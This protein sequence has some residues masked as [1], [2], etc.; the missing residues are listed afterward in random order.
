MDEL[1]KLIDVLEQKGKSSAS[2]LL[3]YSD[4]ESLE[5]RLYQLVREGQPT[6]EKILI[7]ALYGS[8]ATT[9]AY[10][11]LKS[12]VK[13]KLYN[14]LFFLDTENTRIADELAI[15]EVKCRKILYLADLLRKLQEAAFA[16]QQ[17]RKAIALAKESQ[18]IKYEID[19]LEQLRM[20][21]SERNFS[22][23]E[24]NECVERLKI[25]YS[26]LEI[27]KKADNIYYE[28]RFS[29]KLGVHASNE[30]IVKLP[31]MIDR[32]LMFWKA[33]DS[34][35]VFRR[36]HQLKMFYYE[37][38]GDFE[39]FI[40]YLKEIF[41]VYYSGKIHPL[42]FSINF[43]K[44]LLVFAYLRAKQYKEGIK[45]AEE[46][47]T[48]I[49]EGSH[50]WFANMENYFLLAA[51]SKN[52]SKAEELLTEALSNKYL[53]EITSFA[54][55][56]WQLFYQ[57]LN[58]I[59]G[60]TSPTYSGSKLKHVPQDKKG[61]NVWRL[62][63]DFILTL[64]EEDPELIEREI[65]RVRKFSTKYLTAKEDARTKTFLKLL[66]VVGREFSDSKV[67]KRKGAYLFSKLQELPAP[68]IAY[69]ETEI[70]PYEHLWGLILEKMESNK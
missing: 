37:L 13:K 11:M 4:V 17:L 56:R 51:H 69:A 40:L 27:E 22:S 31:E 42:Y 14:Q 34:S 52:Y 1:K 28:I 49:K 25:L 36:Y 19:A 66:Q 65:E 60:F 45:E 29:T 10:K 7:E 63:L 15:V 20:H 12:R 61:Y 43:N 18:F 3:D 44:Y 39:S 64:K 21:F 55:E 30:V 8:A 67:A 50:N 53:N 68:G 24:F 6:D 35:H 32:L 58:Y 16:E 62:I 38:K 33:S 48:K 5:A 59:T 2:A 9:G 46:L 47:K 41:A 57:F 70:I 26:I 54:Q 23:K